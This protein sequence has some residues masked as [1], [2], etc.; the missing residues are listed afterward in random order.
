VALLLG[1][2]LAHIE[3]PISVNPPKRV[4]YLGDPRTGYAKLLVE[5]LLP[6]R[7]R[8]VANR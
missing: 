6:R 1:G 2:Y 4:L 3:R 8:R 7:R 5:V